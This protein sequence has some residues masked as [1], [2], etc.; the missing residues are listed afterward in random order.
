VLEVVTFPQGSAQPQHEEQPDTEDT[1][2][3]RFSLVPPSEST[4]WIS[5][6][7][8]IARSS[9]IP[10]VLPSSPSAPVPF[11]STGNPVS[12]SSTFKDILQIAVEKCERKA[13]E[14][15]ST[16]PFNSELGVCDALDDLVHIFW[17]HTEPLVTLSWKRD[18]SYANQM[19]TLLHF[20]LPKS[21]LIFIN[22]WCECRF[23]RYW[24]LG[25]YIL[26]VVEPLNQG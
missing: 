25:L 17:A 21:I 15:L 20:F 4:R 2:L 5:T 7:R 6:N 9:Y 14:S 26:G 3:I 23:M 13:G 16:Y 12:L 8:S 1:H 19:V 18:H 11:P 24:H 10:P 22:F